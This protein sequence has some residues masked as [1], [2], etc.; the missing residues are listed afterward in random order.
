MHL[1]IVKIMH[2]G[3]EH[4]FLSIY[5]GKIYNFETK[6]EVLIQSAA[7]IIFQFVFLNN[8]SIS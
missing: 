5:A 8:I 1:E 4:F 3:D 6:T 7:Q 2:S